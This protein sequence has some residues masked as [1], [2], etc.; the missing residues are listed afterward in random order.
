MN[1]Q[2]PLGYWP[3]DRPFPLLL[4]A[5]DLRLV[6]GSSTGPMSQATYEKR[7]R[8]FA[9][10]E[11]ENIGGVRYSGAKVLAFVRGQAQT[12]AVT[13]GAKRGPRQVAAGGR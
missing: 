12:H 11:V 3:L 4:T 9:R 2:E 8:Q 5:H 13:F 10:F 6:F 7:R 1:D